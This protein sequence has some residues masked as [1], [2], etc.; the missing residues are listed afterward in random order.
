MGREYLNWPWPSGCE[1]VVTIHLVKSRIRY[2][3]LA[4]T[5]M[6]LPVTFSSSSSFVSQRPNYS[7]DG[8]T[9]QVSRSHT[10]T[11]TH[12]RARARQDFS[13]WAIRLSQR[14]LPTQHTTKK[15][16]EHPIPQPGSNPRIQQTYILERTA[17]RIGYS[18]I[19]RHEFLTRE[20]T[21]SLQV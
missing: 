16:N 7:L 20:T 10:Q 18:Q 11:H 1:G 13:G 2:R 8:L 5:V 12:T 4:N 21:V 19:H 9:V 14:P 17:T 15:G 6:K 3:L